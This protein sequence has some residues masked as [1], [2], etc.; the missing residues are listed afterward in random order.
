[1]R[2][3]KNILVALDGSGPGLHALEE[4]IRLAQWARGRVTAI[5]V[6]PPYEGDLSLVGVRDIKSAISGPC[7]EILGKALDV[8]EAINFPIDVVCEEGEP[9]EKI[10]ERA[11]AKRCD[12]IVMGAGEHRPILGILLGSVMPKVIAHSRQDVLVIPER[13]AID[14]EK[15]LLVADGSSYGEIAVE[16]AIDLAAA[17]GGELKV[18]FTPEA[19]FSASKEG[20]SR[21]EASTSGATHGNTR[22]IQER[23]AKAGLR[24][25]ILAQ[26][27]G[28]CGA[29]RSI[30]EQQGIGMIVTG[31]DGR[32][33]LKR[34]LM[35][36]VAEK[37]IHSAR[38][39]V[40]IA[41]DVQ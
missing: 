11:E 19:F 1:M 14:W 17:Y 3:V 21:G 4:A 22:Y 29:V 13:V 15:M 6:A 40:L 27:G 23:A 35:G 10:L 18:I 37:I 39:P 34:L 5:T 8:A 31:A 41:K 12:L 33:G 2:R 24:C 38:R 26:S 16:R 7:E 25:E 9:H 20:L 32:T 28:V 30:A 36:G